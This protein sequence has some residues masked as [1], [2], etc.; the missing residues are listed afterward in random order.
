[1][2][3]VIKDLFLKNVWM[4]LLSIALAIL[5]WCGI[6]NISDPNVRVTI[7]HVNV[8]KHNEE[9]VTGSGMIYEIDKGDAINV[10]ISGPRSIVQK[11]S[12]QDLDA[13]V[14]LNELS[15][16]NVCPIHVEFKSPSIR[17]SVEIVDKSENVMK[18]KL[19]NM[20]TEHKPIQ[21]EVVGESAGYYAI[22]TSDPLMVEV[23]GSD[24]QISAIEKFVAKVDIT[25]KSS[26]F[27]QLCDVTAYKSS[28][29]SVDKT[30]FKANIDQCQVKV[31]MLHTKV[32]N[33]VMDT[34]ITCEYGFAAGEIIQAPATIEVAAPYDILSSLTEI[35]IP[36]KAKN[37]KET[38]NENIKIADYLP[39]N[40][41]LVSDVDKVSLT[42]PVEMLD[43]EQAYSATVSNIEALNLASDLKVVKN[44]KTYS[45]KAWGV[46]GQIENVKLE[47]LGLY[48]DCRNIKTPG[49]YTLAVRAKNDTVIVDELKIEIE[50]EKVE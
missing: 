35:V 31:T 12:N 36:Y 49:T 16:T 38:I 42:V 41:H 3:N 26:S 11:I 20:V 15:F 43:T 4:K 46:K 6:M 27:E 2:K 29:D 17:N 5:A 22:A 25:G 45:I 33:I 8:T 32:I 7:R 50:I 40:C 37:V 28:G 47:N 39:E 44:D 18:L 24:T 48:I 34:N 10:T 23:Y 21:V 14:D 9:V 19:E 30:K 13:Y 1:M